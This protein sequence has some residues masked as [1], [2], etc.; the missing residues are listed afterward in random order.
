MLTSP[1]CREIASWL[2][3]RKEFES[4]TFMP[5]SQAPVYLF[6]LLATAFHWVLFHVVLVRLDFGDTSQLSS[7]S[8]SFHDCCH[9]PCTSEDLQ[10]LPSRSVICRSPSKLLMPRKSAATRIRS[11]W[12]A[13]TGIDVPVGLFHRCCHVPTCFNTWGSRSAGCPQCQGAPCPLW[14]S[15]V[16]PR[17]SS[18]WEDVP[19]ELPLCGMSPVPSL[20]PPGG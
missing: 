11:M 5:G 4:V 20:Q 2:Y 6:T 8:G 12:A 14:G 3:L 9:V 1:D 15:R 13:T 18:L 17:G 16:S 7:Q 19:M 10:P